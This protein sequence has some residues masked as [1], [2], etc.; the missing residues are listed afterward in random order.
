MFEEQ[1]SLLDQRVV[2][3]LRTILH[4][5]SDK[6]VRRILQAIVP[7]LKP[8]DRIVLNEQIVPEPG[9]ASPMIEKMIRCVLLLN[10]T[11]ELYHQQLTIQCIHRFTDMTMLS[12]FNG[13]ERT[14]QQWES[15]LKSA[16]PDLKIIQMKNPSALAMGIIEISLD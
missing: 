16:H 7:A 5:W 10:D 13:Q 4:N 8:G 9:T 6:Y 3:F 12:N 2:Y 1:E 15:L 14:A 11:S